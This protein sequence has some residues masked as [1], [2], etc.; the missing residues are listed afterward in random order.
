MK[1]AGFGC[2]GCG[3]LIGFLGFAA[4]VA[5]FIPGV[6]NSSE[7]GTAMAV[8]GGLCAGALFPILIGIVLIA[9]GSRQAQQ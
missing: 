1:P 6:V 9:V 5:A 4:I 7:T 2:A 3:A 8:G